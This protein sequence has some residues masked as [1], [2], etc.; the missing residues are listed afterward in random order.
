[1]NKQA[2]F[3]IFVGLYRPHFTSENSCQH[4]IKMCLA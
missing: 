4:Y 3:R 2:Y 1:M